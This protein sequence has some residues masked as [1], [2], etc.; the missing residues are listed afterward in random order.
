MKVLNVPLEPY[1][2]QIRSATFGVRLVVFVE[3]VVLGAFAAFEAYVAFGA[4]VAVERL[5]IG[6][7]IHVCNDS[8]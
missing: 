6:S 2:S 7:G 8:N 1:K 5:A 4:Y 3:F